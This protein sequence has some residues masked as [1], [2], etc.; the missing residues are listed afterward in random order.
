MSIDELEI[1]IE[2]TFL[3]ESEGAFEAYIKPLLDKVKSV[4]TSEKGYLK[5]IKENLNFYVMD[6][7]IETMILDVVDSYISN[8]Y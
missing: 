3:A 8:V 2:E 5:S 6:I 7:N 1:T 4:D